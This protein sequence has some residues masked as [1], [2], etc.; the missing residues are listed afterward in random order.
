[1]SKLSKNYGWLNTRPN[2][3]KTLLERAETITSEICHDRELLLQHCFQLFTL[4]CTDQ[5]VLQKVSIGP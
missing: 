3:S 4:Y 5:F 2:S 1:M